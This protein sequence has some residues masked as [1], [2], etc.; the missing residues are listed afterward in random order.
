MVPFA[1]TRVFTPMAGMKIWIGTI[2]V[3]TA[4]GG[5]VVLDASR[6]EGSNVAEAVGDED[7]VSVDVADGWGTGA[8]SAAIRARSWR[9]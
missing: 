8:A 6:A 1:S 7:E 9:Y 4:A 3:T 2:G 5:D